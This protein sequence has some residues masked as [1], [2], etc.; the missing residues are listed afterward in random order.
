MAEAPA[1]EGKTLTPAEKI[2]LKK[3]E[4]AKKAAAK[5]AKKDPLKDNGDG[6]ISDPN[7]GL[8]WKKNDAW[9][10]THIFYTWMDHKS[11]VD[12]IN[13]EKFA[14]HEDWRLPSKAEAFTLF[15]KSKVCI[16]KNGT[17]FPLDPIFT[18][19]GGAHTWI[20]E[21]SDEQII[22]F[23]MKIGI[24]F[25][26]PTQEVYASIRLVRAGTPPSSDPQAQPPPAPVK[27]EE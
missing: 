21:C 5:A 3:K 2:A 14:G 10:D 24:E 8:M 16:D 13:K 15:D 19:G 22:R 4:A 25:A 18:E 26:Y 23:D 12:K 7:S 1:E 11:Y 20:S 6:T 27:K 9:L 17:G